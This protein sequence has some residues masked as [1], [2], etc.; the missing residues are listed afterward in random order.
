MGEI[1]KKYKSMY[2]SVS[3]QMMGELRKIGVELSE[4]KFTGTLGEDGV[5][6]AELDIVER[7]NG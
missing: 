2:A 7:D 5:W 3:S 6:H 4:I 1:I